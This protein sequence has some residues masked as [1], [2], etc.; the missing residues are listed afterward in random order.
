MD[1]PIPKNIFSLN[2]KPLEKLPKK[3]TVSEYTCGLRY[4]KPNV[5]NIINDSEFF[6]LLTFKFNLFISFL[7]LL[8]TKCNKN[9][10]SNK[11]KKN[12]IIGVKK[13]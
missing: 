6:F 12:I 4:V 13:F 8:H 11:F 3:K 9:T 10:R 2:K 5:L 1:A 7:A